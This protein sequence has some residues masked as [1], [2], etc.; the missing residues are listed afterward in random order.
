MANAQAMLEIAR[1]HNFQVWETLA[2]ILIG[3]TKALMGQAEV[4][5]KEVEQ[6]FARYQG[7]NSPPVF[8]PSIIALRALALAH[9]GQPKKGLALLNEQLDINDQRRLHRDMLPM[10]LLKGDL[11]L[12]LSPPNVRETAEIY[13]E[14]LKDSQHAGDRMMTLQVA[15]RLCEMEVASGE[16][17]GSGQ[18]LAEMYAG[19]TEGFETIDLQRAK[20]ALDAWEKTANA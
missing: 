13:Q 1:E 17:A 4:G 3:T 5:Q 20:A 10:Q 8:Y 2:M 19:F 18:A 14:I 15:T 12:N 9:I 7:L 11:L 16:P 6:G